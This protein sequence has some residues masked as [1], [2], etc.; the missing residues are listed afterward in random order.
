M[1]TD[2]LARI[3]KLNLNSDENS[4]GWMEEA[5]RAIFNIEDVI[6]DILEGNSFISPTAK[7][8]PTAIIGENVFIDS[9]VEIGPYSFIRSYV[10]LGEN[11]KIGFS[12]EVDRCI[13]FER[14]K[15]AHHA[16]IGRC[17]IGQDSNLAYG[18]VVATRNILNRPITINLPNSVRLT[19]PRNHHGSVI[20]ARFVTGVNVAT[21]PGATILTD[22]TVGPGVRISGFL[23]SRTIMN[24]VINLVGRVFP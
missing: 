6:L 18:F 9:N 14:V 3:R 5:H 23:P 13:L 17:I 8:H 20:G 24:E 15:A 19:S 2:R 10:V 4:V 1:S 16:S 21:M 22:V 11:T 12:V 7:I